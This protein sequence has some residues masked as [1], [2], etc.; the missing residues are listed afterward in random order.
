M[1]VPDV[2]S[3]RKMY[4]VSGQYKNHEKLGEALLSG[5]KEAG[6]KIWSSGKMAIDL[7]QTSYSTIPSVDVE[8]GDRKSS[9][10]AGTLEKIANGVTYGINNLN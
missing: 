7:T 8:V 2:K 5:F 6:V 3:Y 1:T 10:D 4:P 9:H